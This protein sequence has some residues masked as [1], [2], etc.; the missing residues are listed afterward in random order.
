MH[1]FVGKITQ[2]LMVRF[3]LNFQEM[4]T[5]VHHKDRKCTVNENPSLRIVVSVHYNV[6]D[7]I[8]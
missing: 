3:R 8:L 7:I 1:L 2:K 6:G 5:M 4:M